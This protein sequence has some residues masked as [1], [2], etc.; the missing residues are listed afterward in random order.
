MPQ[1]QIKTVDGD[2]IADCIVADVLNPSESPETPE[3]LENAFTN[4]DIIL[5]AS[6]SVPVA[7]HLVHD[8][9]S[10]G[11]RISI[12][13]N[14][15]GT[16]V[17]ILAEDAKRK[18]SLDFLEMQYYRYL[19]NDVCLADHLKRKHGRIRFATSC[20]DVSATIPQD[21]VALQAAICSRAIHQLS[22]NEQAFMSIWRTDEDQI[23]VQRYSF[24]VKN[25]IKCKIGEWTLCTDEGFIDKVHEAR[26]NKLP[27]ETGGVLVGS[28]DMQRKIVYVVDFLPSPPDS[29]EWPT[30]YIRG[31]RGLPS[32]IEKIQQVTVNQLRYVGEWHSHPAACSVKPSHDDKQVFDWLSD[33]MKIDGLP[34][35]MLI[36]GDP[37]TVCFLLRKNR[38]L[39]KAEK[40]LRLEILSSYDSI[41]RVTK[42]IF[43]TVL[44][45]C[46]RI[47]PMK[48]L[49]E[50]LSSYNIFN[51]LLPG[52]LFVGLGKEITS[53][54]LV[55]D[56]L[57][58][59]LFFYY[60]I[61][62]IISRIGSLTLEELLR[63]KKIKFVKFAEY[64]DYIK[65]SKLD[66]KIEILS[67]QNN[68]YRSLCMLS[69]ALI[70]LKIYDLVW[71]SG[72]SE[73]AAIIFI[74]L[75]GLLVLFLFSYKKQTEKY[76]VKRVNIALEKEEV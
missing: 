2:P 45:L 76:V 38:E 9:D 52:I 58:I 11:R 6:A 39:P 49:L 55:Q 61:G 40:K 46:W 24:P 69:I 74:F 20:R 12:F 62:L 26:A 10:S 65:A 54:S 56:N 43:F 25:S 19:I 70:L 35:L 5:D 57:L 66:P 73:N 48:D 22:S 21:F 4:A 29:K 23:S 51:Y 71:G 3:K 42:T 15:D 59:G 64:E 13:L 33:L 50:K 53:F 41:A 63:N 1:A 7:R 68:M 75:T 18:I 67:E 8:V 47:R 14:P 31:C 28:Y 17:V 30:L 32:K 44:P 36:V 34:P 27:N 37:G 16:D 72:S 60:F